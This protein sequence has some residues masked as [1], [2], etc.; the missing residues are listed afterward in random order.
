MEEEYKV[1]VGRGWGASLALDFT[2]KGGEKAECTLELPEETD[3]S[4]SCPP[5]EH[6]TFAL[7]HSRPL[8]CLKLDSCHP[9]G[10]PDKDQDDSRVPQAD[11]DH[12]SPTWD[13]LSPP[14]QR[15]FFS[16]KGLG[17]LGLQGQH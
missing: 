6:R 1:G 12:V 5:D 14:V 17:L 3:G 11:L 13:P 2:N 7:S 10:R 4:H 16:S 8:K 9:D 15:G